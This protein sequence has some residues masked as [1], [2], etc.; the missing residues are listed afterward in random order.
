M[1]GTTI[2]RLRVILGADSTELDRGLSKSKAQ[3]RAISLAIAGMAAAAGTAMLGITRQVVSG[4]NEIQQMARVANAVP[5]EFQKWAAAT[6]TIGIE[7]DKLADILKD[8][9][10]RVGDFLSTGGGP[11]ADF[12]ENIAPKV[13]VTA[14]QFRHLS[15]PQALQLY[16]DSLEKAGV[17]QGEMTFY[18]EAM[19]SDLTMMLPLLRSG[20]AEMGRLGDRAEEFGAVL[21]GD[22]LAAMRRAQVA[23]S[24]VGLVFKG[25]AYQ[26]ATALTPVLEAA[27]TA[28]TSL[29]TQ[30]QPLNVLFT[31]VASNLGRIASYGAAAATV[32]GTQYVAAMVAARAA[33]FTLSG[34]LAFLRGAIMRT[35]VGV[36]IVLV[37]EAIHRLSRLV[38]S[39]GGVGEAMS[40]LGD[41]AIEVWQRIGNGVDFIR[42]SVAAM[43]NSINAI[44]NEALNKMAVAWV[45][46]T[47]AIADGLNA[48]F[49][50][51]LVGADARITQVTAAAAKG[52]RAAAAAS[53]AAAKSASDAFSA[54]LE[55]LQKLQDKMAQTA[56]DAA[57]V[58]ADVGGAGGA[59][60]GSGAGDGSDAGGGASKAAEKVKDELTEV[61]T[62][63]ESA[64]DSIESSFTDAFKSIATRSK[65]MGEAISGVLSSLADMLLDNVGTFLFSGIASKLGTA[66]A[67]AI[68][69]YANGTQNHPG[70]LAWVGERGRELVNLPR[71]AQVIPNH[72]ISEA[73]VGQ[74]HVEITPSPY[75]DARVT[76]LS[77][78]ATAPMLSG[79]ARAGQRSHGGLSSK[80]YERGTTT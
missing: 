53:E 8:V 40:L 21:D 30:G 49:D 19:A 67:G 44:F 38:T 9:N 37:G 43:G 4:A 61:E 34:A 69:A 57:K 70:G 50:T 47:W 28:F 29:A 22:T 63:A 79:V 10:D 11:M 15:G 77:V 45:E 24:E 7:Q 71:G 26:I 2:G 12:F 20:G 76:D 14:E 64:A 16:V 48:L 75:F 73:P 46:F 36:I 78:N 18:L 72:R 68:P 41:V 1:A 13:G 62:R 42:H 59:G 66:V 32:F 17:S 74:A 33:T 3:F 56:A 65:T 51:N 31:T 5:E 80:M 27:A 23:V 54:P 55:S 52:A 35:G 25:F 60:S 39:V 6:S 58:A